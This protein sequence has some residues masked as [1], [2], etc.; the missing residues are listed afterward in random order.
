[1]KLSHFV[2]LWSIFDLYTKIQ[3]PAFCVVVKDNDMFAPTKFGLDL[4]YISTVH[5][6]STASPGAFTLGCSRKA[7]LQYEGV[8]DAWGA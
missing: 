1:M 5:F 2:S 8:G 6:A 7:W 4:N 3:V